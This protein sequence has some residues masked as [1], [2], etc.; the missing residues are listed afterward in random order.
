MKFQLKSYMHA[1]LGIYSADA[2]S[3]KKLLMKC[4][5]CNGNVQYADCKLVSSLQKTCSVPSCAGLHRPVCGYAAPA[6]VHWITC[7]LL[8]FSRD[9]DVML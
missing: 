2:Q 3:C 5:A 6:R 1:V 9:G 8:N 4:E 7:L